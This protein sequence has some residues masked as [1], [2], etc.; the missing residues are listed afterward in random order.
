MMKIDDSFGC[1]DIA[2]LSYSFLDVFRIDIIFTRWKSSM[3]IHRKNS[4]RTFKL[5]LLLALLVVYAF[6]ACVSIHGEQR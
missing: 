5:L 4:I 3:A 6:G 1:Y 2:H